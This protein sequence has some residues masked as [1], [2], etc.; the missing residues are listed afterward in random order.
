MLA[1]F[2]IGSPNWLIPAIIVGT[3]LTGLVL[4]NYASAGML[5]SRLGWTGIALKVA[6]IALL[7]ACLLQPMRRA[8]R[9]RPRANLLPVVVD[10]SRSMDLAIGRSGS[11]R[12]RIE[13]ALAPDS[14]LYTELAQSFDTRLYGFD[15][16]LTGASDVTALRRGGRASRLL[17]AL[18]EMG[19]RM[20]GRP[21]AGMLLMT[22]GNDPL[23][24]NGD[25]ELPE[26]AFPVFP[27]LPL[28]NQSV[29]DLRI[30]GTTVR[31]TNFE[32]S[33]VTLTA[34]YAIEGSLKGKA[35]ATLTDTA[36]GTLI[37]E[38]TI[39]LANA[40]DV[41]SVTFQFRPVDVGL[42]FY[43]VSLFR[44]ADRVAFDE[45]DSLI[46]TE[47]SETTLVNNTQLVSVDRGRGPYRVLYVAGRPNWEFKFLRRAIEEDSEVQLRGLFR[48]AKKALKFNFRDR[49]IS[50]TN[51]LFQGLGEDAEEVAEQYDEPVIIRLGLESPDELA[52]GFPKTADE[53]F[54]FD[55]L[56]L[57]DIEPGFFSRD[58][59][60]MVRGFVANRGG[61]LL[62]LGGQEMF[63]GKRFEE[64]T[65]GELC[66]VYVARGASEK[67]SGPVTL[68]LTREGMLQPWLRLRDNAS[69]ETIRLRSMP[70]FASA[71]T[72][73]E[74][75][76]GAYQ[77]ATVTTADGRREPAVAI[78][79]F[80]NGKVGAITITDLWRWSMRRDP[81]H[82]DDAAQAWR[83]ITRWLVSDV[84]RR[85]QLSATPDETN[86]DQTIIRVD[87]ADEEY[88][89]MDNASVSV[90]VDSPGN[91][92]LRL[93][94]KP[95]GETAG[96][97]TVP[98]FGD[99]PGQYTVSADVR[100]PDGQP[101]QVR[102]T[103]WTR[104]L[105]G[106]E[107]DQLGTNISLLER[108]AE[109]SGGRVIRE[110]DLDQFSNR[111]QAEKVPVTETWV[112]PLWHRGWVI[113][114]ALGCL[115]CEWGIR[116]W[117]GLA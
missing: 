61:G 64:S 28:G 70:S 42:R 10:T 73:G 59:L 6:G 19:Q 82:A 72:V 110:Q 15:K 101:M 103:G 95:V 39:D 91:E 58:Q 115:C 93:D 80:G 5:R 99:L 23:S 112:Y 7:A 35:F 4:W 41:G 8:T 51:P 116:R 57:D 68:G 49:N 43:R 84:P 63:A 92:P 66:P 12:D 102:E 26:F 34:R 47:S 78:H 75:K 48:M 52:S 33:P 74:L 85:T 90:I 36:T 31:Q 98:Y 13:T 114:L 21:V 55:A 46:D 24:L 96:A 16:R 79:R 18:D 40:D 67:A 94:A 14:E 83:Q 17:T 37:E 76:A 54:S 56:I 11:W 71:N 87:V 100:A 2:I 20:E 60:D 25:T 27:V 44:E 81:E 29:D 117:G 30:T 22:D 32:L 1:E 77:F 104:Q 65:L 89:P 113:A 107:F 53:L 86:A 109:K 38:Q 3:V 62:M 50:T 88:E 97:Y 45:P 105:A 111:L 9:P 106:G 69:E 108:I